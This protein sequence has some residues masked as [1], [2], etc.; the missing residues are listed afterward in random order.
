MPGKHGKTNVFESDSSSDSS[1]VAFKLKNSHWNLANSH[2]SDGYSDYLL[3]C[4]DDPLLG[5]TVTEAP[6]IR[7]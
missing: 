4:L 6:R 1:P 5:D 7:I 3:F 2:G